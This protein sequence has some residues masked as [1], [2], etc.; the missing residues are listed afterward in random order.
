M[1][2]MIQKICILS[3]M[4]LS[5]QSAL[6]SGTEY[7]EMQK[8]ELYALETACGVEHLYRTRL[9]GETFIEVR[10]ITVDEVA[11]VTS[12]LETLKAEGCTI[13]QQTDTTNK[14]TVFTDI[15]PRDVDSMNAWIQ[16]SEGRAVQLSA[17]Q[18]VQMGYETKPGTICLMAHYPE[19]P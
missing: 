18:C 4:V 16:F 14:T 11:L 3:L 8:R 13:P 2:T 19:K 1:K 6:A 12:R 5:A 7:Y 9:P 10:Q 17:K 15:D